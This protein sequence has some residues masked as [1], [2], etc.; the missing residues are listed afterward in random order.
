MNE[1]FQRD[2][3]KLERAYQRFRTQYATDMALGPHPLDATEMAEVPVVV[4]ATDREFFD[5][6][7]PLD[8]AGLYR[9]AA[10]HFDLRRDAAAGYF[11]AVK[12]IAPGHLGGQ[13]L[14]DSM[15]RRFVDHV[16]EHA[17][18][19]VWVAE[20]LGA[21]HSEDLVPMFH[22]LWLDDF[23]RTGEVG[24]PEYREGRVVARREIPGG[25]AGTL[26]EVELAEDPFGYLRGA[27]TTA[28]S[29]E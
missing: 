25:V 18:G 7:A 5:S 16:A 29:G 23:V 19:P 12:E 22:S 13:L 1:L 3:A 8:R 17:P 10:R 11:A 26:N 24:W 21:R 28:S 14:S 9:L 20:H 15:C 27:F 6:G 4:T 2:P